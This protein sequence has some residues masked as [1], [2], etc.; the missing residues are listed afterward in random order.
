MTPAPGPPASWPVPAIATPAELA[1]FLDLEPNELD[2][3]ADCQSR[4]RSAT[5][6]PLRHYRYR[7]MAK[8][9]GSL[10]LIEAPKPRLKQL[11][12]R[13][14]DAILLHI[15]P[16]DAAH[17]FRPGRSVTTFVAP[18]VGRTIVLKM[19]LR[20]FFVSITSARVIALYLTA[21]YPEAVARLLA[22]LCTNTVP[23][24][25]GTSRLEPELDSARSPATWQARR[26]YRAAAPA[27]GCAD[28]AGAGQPGRLPARRAA[29][30]PGAG[31]RGQLHPLRRRPG[32]LR[33]RILRAVDRP[34]PDPRRRDR[35]RGRFRRPAPQDTGHATGSQATGRRGRDQ[36]EDQYRAG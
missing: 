30:R 21:G 31:R 7:W 34:V 16:H 35:A 29:G 9:S 23:L 32:L 12:R 25:S 24:T 15:P 17:G 11:Q 20:D 36:S 26:L 8:P 3:F 33:R 6:E 1:G 14:L 19:D 28:L 4:E 5:V 10:R 2:W 22:G 27:P 18:H 13:L